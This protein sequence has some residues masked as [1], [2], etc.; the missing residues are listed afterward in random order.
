M[1]KLKP[2]P[3]CGGVAEMDTLRA[4]LA[5]GTGR[6]GHALAVYCTTCS[7]D[8]AVCYADVPD[9]QPEQVADMWNKREA[10]D[11]ATLVARLARALRRAAPEHELPAIALDYLQRN[12]LIGSPLRK[13][14]NAVVSGAPADAKE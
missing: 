13:T 10:D 7:A 4:Y 5:L 11:I 14:P 6:M 9:I 8:I 12:D 2:C 3:F 1:N